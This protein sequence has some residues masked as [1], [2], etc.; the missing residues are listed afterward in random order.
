MAKRKVKKEVPLTR[1]QVSRR[2][3]ERRQRLIMMGVAAFVGFV[4]VAILAYGFYMERIVKPASPVA[5]VNG[6]AIPTT[7]YQ[8]RVLLQRMN[9]D[10]VMNNLQLQRSGLDPD[11]DQFLINFID[12]QLSQL[13]MQRT[14]VNGEDFVNELIREELITQA[15]EE[16]GIVV[17][18]E[19][20]ARRIEEDF[21]YYREPP[22]PV[23]SPTGEPIT[24]TAE[25]TPTATP[26]PMTRARFAEL[27]GEFLTALQEAT[28][29]SEAE[30]GETVKADLLWDKMEEFVGQQVPT[31]E[32]QIHARHILVETK[33]EAEAVLERLEAGEDF[34]ALAE[35][36]SQDPGSGEE[37]GDLGWFPQGRMVP[38][39]DE[40]AFSLSPGEIS[41]AV[42]TSFG[43]HIIMIEERDEE[44][45]LDPAMLEQRIGEAFQVWLLDLEATAT[46]ER[47]WSEHKVPP[48]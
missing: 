11:Q 23:P 25:I 17:S 39:F 8:K 2:E 18:S 16:S 7:T 47:Y 13:T 22:T 28:G 46:I 45:E 42:E 38:E 44:R 29:M 9:L 4:I 34:A 3:K 40:V 36:L 19:D 21:G 5:V 15:A 24:A 35:E 26:T 43:F 37:G 41:D 32:L 31:S 1:K 20:V 14:L 30:Y 6:V 10:T 48:E 27:Y 33:E 12:Q